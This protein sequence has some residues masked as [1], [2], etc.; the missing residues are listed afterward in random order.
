MRSQF[1][2]FY[3]D[4]HVR[5]NLVSTNG[6]ENINWLFFPGGPGADSSYFLNL[7]Q[8]VQAPGNVWLIDFPGNGSH[9]VKQNNFD[10]WL[11]IFLPTIQRFDNP[12]LVGHSF[13]GQMPL[14]FPA[15]EDILLGLIIF[16]ASPCL[17][18]E[19]AV[20]MAQVLNLPDLSLEMQAFS[21]NPNQETFNKALS[22]CTP[23]YFPEKTL[24]IGKKTLSDLA[25]NFQPAVWWQR[26]A[27]EINFN[28]T[29]IP[30]NI[31][32]LIVGAEFDAITP[33]SLFSKD[34]RF[35]RNN[36]TKHLIQDAGHFPWLD[37]PEEV[38]ELFRTFLT[39]IHKVI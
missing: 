25:I 3:D 28:A 20:A 8:I 39:R 19:E 34:T 14:L 17:W 15:L 37:Q 7:L 6:V 18:L 23:Y 9:T 5:Y 2:Y 32:T 4:N 30:Q 24:A 10:T 36:I 29:W 38:K 35:E 12:I 11:D 27:V 22:A 26:K 33:F 21:E 13:G 31:P 16:N 1:N